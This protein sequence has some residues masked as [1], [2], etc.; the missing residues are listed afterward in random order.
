MQSFQDYLRRVYR[1][2]VDVEFFSRSTNVGSIPTDENA[3]ASDSTSA[4]YRNKRVMLSTTC[5][6]YVKDR[7]AMRSHFQSTSHK[8]GRCVICCRTDNCDGNESGSAHGHY[9]AGARTKFGCGTCIVKIAST[10]KT[11]ERKRKRESLSRGD[12]SPVKQ[13]DKG[14]LASGGSLFLSVQPSTVQPQ[15]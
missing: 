7:D 10:K 15:R 1:R 13:L 5:S 3:T 12:I 8:Y 2:S 14:N 11:L 4:K 6:K 9:R